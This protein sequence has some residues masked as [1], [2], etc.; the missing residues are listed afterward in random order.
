MTKEEKRIK[1]NREIEQVKIEIHRS[2]CK[3]V[4]L[5]NKYSRLVDKLIKLGV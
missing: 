5:I 4:K 2:G 1:L 3:D